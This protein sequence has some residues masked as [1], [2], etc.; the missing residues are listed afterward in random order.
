MPAEV[1]SAPSVPL[2][3]GR[4]PLEQAFCVQLERLGEWKRLR[5][6]I[7][8]TPQGADVLIWLLKGGNRVRPLK[9]LYRG[10]R[11][12]E[13]TI[14]WVLKALVD[15][16]FITI[17]KSLDDHRV[18]GV[19]INPKLLAAVNE[20]LIHLRNCGATLAMI[21]APQQSDLSAVMAAA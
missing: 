10:S 12:S 14:R 9:D 19:R 21:E 5:M 18:R 1:M 8:N 20:Y 13:P 17:E 3:K 16:G 6:P 7:L 4:P 11:F 2:T 15:D